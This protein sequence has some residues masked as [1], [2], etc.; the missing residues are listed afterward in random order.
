MLRVF[1]TGASSG[2]GAALAREYAQQG[3]RLG[4]LARRGDALQVDHQ[5]VAGGEGEV[6]VQVGVARH[7]DLGGQGAQARGHDEEVHV[8]RA[9]AVVELAKSIVSVKSPVRGT[10][11]A[12]NPLSLRGTRQIVLASGGWHKLTVIRAALKLLRPTVL[13]VNELVAERLAAE[14]R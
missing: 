2:L 12:I 14:E 9:V 8:G 5:A 10:V 7:V 13:I 3:A 1:I 6:V 4:L 11:V